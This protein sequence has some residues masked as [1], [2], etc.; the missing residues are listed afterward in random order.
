MVWSVT[1]RFIYKDEKINAIANYWIKNILKEHKEHNK[2]GMP[3]LV[4]VIGLE[5][6]TQN[7]I[8]EHTVLT[9]L[10]MDKTT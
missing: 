2:D 8:Y 4:C 3:Y 7:K 1:I 9:E 10:P 5:K 6:Y